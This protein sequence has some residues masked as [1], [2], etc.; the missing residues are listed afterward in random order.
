MKL[1]EEFGLTKEQ[2]SKFKDYM[3]ILLE[4]NKKFNLTAITN[5]DEIEEKHFIDSIELINFVD[6]KNKTLL[7]VGSGAGFPGVPLAIAEPSAKITL[8]ESNGKRI[9]FL[10]EVIKKLDL[11]NVE[12][13]QGRSEELDC[14]EKYDIV[15]AR[16]VK[17]LSI[18]LE[19][20]FYLVKVGGRF[21]AYKSAGINEEL[22]NCKHAF[23]CLQ[24]NEFKKH[25]YV[26][27]KSKNHRVFLEIL[28]NN[29]TQKKY[30]RKYGEISKQ[31]L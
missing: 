2:I 10:K 31:P 3:D 19:I 13:I 22:N 28:K 25:E 21:V 17:E 5:E 30:P 8:L 14:R 7:D 11:K 15:T 12:I 24:I 26:L 27:P 29:K 4:W 18:L 6:I 9:S 1:L 23:K 20:C 16:A